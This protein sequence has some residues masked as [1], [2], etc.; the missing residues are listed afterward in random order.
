MWAVGVAA[1]VL[2]ACVVAIGSAKMLHHL[3]PPPGTDGSYSA[4]AGYHFSL[5]AAA[6]CAAAGLSAVASLSWPVWLPWAGF[7]GMGVWMAC[8]DAVTGFVPRRVSQVTA[9]V[10]AILVIVQAVVEGSTVPLTRSVVG[11]AVVWLLFGGLW[12]LSRGAVGFGDVRFSL[13]WAMTAAAAS[14]QHLVLAGVL[15]SVMPAPWRDRW[16]SRRSGFPLYA[17]VGGRPVRRRPPLGPT[18][19]VVGPDSRTQ[20]PTGVREGVAI[21]L[22]SGL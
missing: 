8:V 2:V 19:P 15:G 3:P 13:P 9:G 18:A 7:A 4:A 11:G 10:I 20:W 22:R 5:G 17:G 16:G 14:W 6:L 12:L 21:V 1:V